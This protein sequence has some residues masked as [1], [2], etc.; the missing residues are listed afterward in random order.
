MK[1]TGI[2][3]SGGEKQTAPPDRIRVIRAVR[4]TATFDG[5]LRDRFDNHSRRPWILSSTQRGRTSTAPKFVSP[6]LFFDFSFATNSA[7]REANQ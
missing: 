2:W 4:G 1:A 5:W 7:E 3:E 6:E